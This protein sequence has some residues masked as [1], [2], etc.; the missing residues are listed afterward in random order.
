MHVETLPPNTF[1]ATRYERDGKYAEMFTASDEAEARRICEERGWTYEGQAV[2][3]IDGDTSEDEVS[4]LL[5]AMN[6][7]GR[8]VKH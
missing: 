3:T 1:L 8:W 7:A 2:Y 4:D 6:E 5:E